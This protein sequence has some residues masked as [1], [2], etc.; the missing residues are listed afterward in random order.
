MKQRK[1]DVQYEKDD[2]IHSAFQNREIIEFDLDTQQAKVVGHWT[3]WEIADEATKK[4]NELELD[5]EALK[6]KHKKELRQAGYDQ[7]D[8]Y[9]KILDRQ[10]WCKCPNCLKAT[11]LTEV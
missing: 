8:A 6:E 5:K 10:T 2:S 3:D 11:K 9:N 1:I 7:L 4:F